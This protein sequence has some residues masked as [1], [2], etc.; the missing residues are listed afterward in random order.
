MYRVEWFEMAVN[1]LA[2]IWINATPSLRSDIT[3]A[4]HR[5]EN[6]LRRKPMETGESRDEGRRIYFEPPLVIMYKIVRPSSVIIVDIAKLKPRG[7]Q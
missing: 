4:S 6:T 5:I 7:K 2:D 1:K 3:A